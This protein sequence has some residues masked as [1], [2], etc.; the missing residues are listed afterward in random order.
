MLDKTTIEI[1]KSTLPAISEAG[2]AITKHFYE[3]MLSRHPEL[4]NIFNMAHQRDLTQPKAL[5]DAVC[6]YAQH[7]EE[8]MQLKE[9]VER[10]AY[11]HVS[12]NIQ[13]EHY[14]IVGE[15]LLGSIEELL[16]PGEVVLDAWKN[17]Y[18]FLAN[19]FISTEGM[20][21]QKEKESK[22]G[23]VGTRSFRIVKKTKE[24]E[25]ITSFILEPVDGQPVMKFLPGQYISVYIPDQGWGHQAIRQYSLA[26]LADGKTYRIAVKNED[27]GEVSPFL[28]QKIEEG[29][30]IDL[31]AP[32]GD[33]FLDI[34]AL[35]GPVALIS[36]GVG[37]TPML[38]MLHALHSVKYNKPVHWLHSA[39]DSGS[40]AF[41]SEVRQLI[42]ELPQASSDVWHVEPGKKDVQGKDFDHIGFMM[43]N[44]VKSYFSE[45]KLTCYLCGPRPFMRFCKEQLT[46]LGIPEARIHYELFGSFEPI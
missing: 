17:A 26:C 9:A 43:L 18:A 20:M 8:P 16:N 24:S 25:K 21:Y 22:G 40:H 6:A 42:A 34:E 38:A 7:I 39:L 35:D 33:F 23:W 37:Q 44:E 28:H 15:N 14:A 41:G 45:E 10:I 13:P 12:L 31:S 4:Q 11:K 3:R 36:G 30:L 32:G 1:V 46:E 29:S 19:I 27:K 2:T 5:F